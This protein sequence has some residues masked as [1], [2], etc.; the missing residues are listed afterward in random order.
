MELMLLG[1]QVDAAT[2]LRLGLLNRVVDGERLMDE[3]LAVADRLLERSGTALEV[4]K[5]AVLS[6]SDMPAEAAFHAE[7]RFG[8]EAFASPDAREGLR[9]FAERRP[10][11]FPSRAR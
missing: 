11:S 6:L 2:A 1:D 9:A 10:P 3:A 8:Q 7:A 4:V 5:S